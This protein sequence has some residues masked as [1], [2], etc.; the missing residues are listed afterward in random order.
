[1]YYIKKEENQSG[2]RNLSNA[3]VT[4]QAMNANSWREVGIELNSMKKNDKEKI[5]KRDN[6]T[7]DQLYRVLSLYKKEQVQDTSVDELSSR[8]NQLIKF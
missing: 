6:N 4:L 3:G 1:M 7:A 5:T 8:F 2:L